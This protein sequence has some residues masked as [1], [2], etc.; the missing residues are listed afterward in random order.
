MAGFENQV[1]FTI[2][3]SKLQL[4]EVIYSDG[5]FVLNNVDEA[6]FNESLNFEK[7]KETKIF[8]LLQGA[9]NELLIKKPLQSTSVSFALP[10]ELFYVMQVPYDNTLLHQDLIEEFKW[11]FSVLYPYLSTNDFVIQYF[12][13]EKNNLID[14]STVIVIAIPRKFLQIIHNF[15]NNNNLKLKFIDNIHVASERALMLNYPSAS[16]GLTMSA[17]LGNKYFSLIFSLDGKPIYF[18][19]IPLNDAAEIPSLLLVETSPQKSF[20]ISRNQIDNAFITGEEISATIIQTLNNALE[21]DFKYFNPFDK[22]KPDPNLFGNKYYS[23]KFN[24]FSPSAGI[25]YRLA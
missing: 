24:S 25:A 22:I 5:R 12:E 16:R 10:F 19:V 20:N 7:D 1:G 14:Q 23:E 6:Y 18:K 2:S 4:A 3:N 17:Y 15:C 9:F 11:E 21:I 8:S 13:V